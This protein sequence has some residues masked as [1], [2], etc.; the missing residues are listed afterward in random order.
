MS[1]LLMLSLV[2]LVSAFVINGLTGQRVCRCLC[3]LAFQT[4][5][6]ADMI[7]SAAETVQPSGPS[8]L[9]S[10]CF[11][12]AGYKVVPVSLLNK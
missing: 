12:A 1:A 6:F 11:A 10:R 7:S 2:S 8:L 3:R 4:L 9:A 5:S